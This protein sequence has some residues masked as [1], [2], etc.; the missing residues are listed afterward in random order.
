MIHTIQ[1]LKPGHLITLEDYYYYSEYDEQVYVNGDYIVQA[2]EYEKNK[3]S[4][5]ELR[6][7]HAISY[8]LL[9]IDVEVLL[10]FENEVIFK[11]LCIDTNKAEKITKHIQQDIQQLQKLLINFH[12]VYSS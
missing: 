8:E 4:L 3:P 12:T 2:V 11:T 1:S 10:E 7:A 5:L 9:T 6:P